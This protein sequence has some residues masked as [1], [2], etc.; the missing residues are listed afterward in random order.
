MHAYTYRATSHPQRAS[1]AADEDLWNFNPKEKNSIKQAAKTEK[2]EKAASKIADPFDFSEFEDPGSSQSSALES[3]VPQPRQQGPRHDRSQPADDSDEDDDLLGSLK[4]VKPAAREPLPIGRKAAAPAR[5]NGSASPPPHIIGQIVEMGF[6]PTQARQALAATQSG[7]DV[8]AALEMLLEEQRAIQPAQ[9]DLQESDHKMAKRLQREE[10][11]RRPDR[12]TANRTGTPEGSVKVN[13]I[14]VP[15]EWQ[16]QADQIYSQASEIGASM[17]SKANA[18]WSTAKAQAQKALDERNMGA[19]SGQS[20]GRSSPATGSERAKSRR[21]AVPSRDGGN[22]RKEWQGKPKW[23]VDAEN[24]ADTSAEQVQTQSSF[25]D[26]ADV[27]DEAPAKPFIQ[28]ET[29]TEKK[30]SHL[31]NPLD[32]WESGDANGSSSIKPTASAPTSRRSS[33]LATGAGSS[34]QSPVPRKAAVATTKP[35]QVEHGTHRHMITDDAGAIQSSLTLK[36]RGNELFKQG[37]YIEAE[38][39]YTNALNSLQAASLRKVALFNNRAS[40]RL[41]N[42]DARNALSDTKEVLTLIVMTESG[43]GSPFLLYRPSKEYPLPLPEYADINLRDGYAK[44][45][46]RRAQAEEMLE[47]WETAQS[48]WSLLE[49]YEKEEGSGKSGMTNLRAAQ[50]G[51]KRCNTML[52]GGDVVLTPP[53]TQRVRAAAVQAIAKA[54]RL[55]KERI[56]S[57]NAIAAKE[58]AEKDSLRDNVDNRVATWKNNK[59]TNVRALLAS[60]HEVVWPG[61][62]WKKVGMHE[63]VMD[64]Q[65]KKCYMRAIGKLHP[66]KVNLSLDCCHFS[67]DIILLLIANTKDEYYRR[68]YGWWCRLFG[69]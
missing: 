32:L 1:A 60:L 64:N 12:Q 55:A 26:D 54:E 11:R 23:M 31:L 35:V 15:Q 21:W 50:E 40:A 4:S 30:D 62:G 65:V 61:L 43:K 69:T 48:V 68:A 27:R 58:E 38:V 10:E 14:E 45:L 8:S 16:K 66:D 19:E 39:A 33:P 13:G 5:S 29:R 18:L 9:E 36:Q 57:E 17:F 7:L 22:H 37:A 41:K 59:E 24:E 6:S 46:L 56:R 34:R 20:S 28:R 51:G 3:A 2:V 25:K 52:R 42:G 53:A 63:L 44:A 49:R 47:Q 67:A